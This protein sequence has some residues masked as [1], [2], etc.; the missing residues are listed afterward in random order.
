[1][2]KAEGENVL[3]FLNAISKEIEDYKEIKKIRKI[4][5]ENE[6]LV[7]DFDLKQWRYRL[8]YD[9]SLLTGFVEGVT[10]LIFPSRKPKEMNGIFECIYDPYLRFIVSHYDWRLRTLP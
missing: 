9:D 4:E 10:L 8:I 3:N 1:M 5:K 2:S 6:L 7:Y